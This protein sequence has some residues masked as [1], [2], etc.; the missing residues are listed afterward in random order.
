MSF[1]V[2]AVALFVKFINACKAT[3][4]QKIK[5]LKLSPQKTD[6]KGCN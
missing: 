4:C 2:Q 6:L 1:E 3:C 5:P